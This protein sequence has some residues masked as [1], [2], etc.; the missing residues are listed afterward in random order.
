M[1]T[2]QPHRGCRSRRV[3]LRLEAVLKSSTLTHIQDDDGGVDG[4]LRHQCSHHRQ[5]WYQDLQRP[6]WRVTMPESGNFWQLRVCGSRMEGEQSYVR[7]G[8]ELP[9]AL[10]WIGKML[11][12]LLDVHVGKAI[13]QQPKSRF[14]RGSSQWFQ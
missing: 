14:Y 8:Q 11:I 12:S 10:N 1:L 13:S 7:G 4:S 3:D 9:H 5:A 6:S 2:L